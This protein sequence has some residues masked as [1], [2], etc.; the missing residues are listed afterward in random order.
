M[1]ELNA[2]FLQIIISREDIENFNF[3]PVKN[4]LLS[5]IGNREVVIKFNG[6]VILLIDGYNSDSR[7]LFEIQQVR[8]FILKLDSFFPYWFY[9]ISVG[10]GGSCIGFISRALCKWNKIMPGIGEYDPTDL[11]KFLSNHF[12]ALNI[13]VDKFNLPDFYIESITNRII[14]ALGLKK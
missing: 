2:D 7:E 14:T 1:N 11:V 13:L 5:L 10:D 3:Y 6:R 4:T 9:F 12:I 8:D